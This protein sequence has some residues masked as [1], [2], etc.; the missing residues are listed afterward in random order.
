MLYPS[1]SKTAKSRLLDIYDADF[2]TELQ[3]LI[4]SLVISSG[5]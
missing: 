4:N 1:A 3:P 2:T 5:S